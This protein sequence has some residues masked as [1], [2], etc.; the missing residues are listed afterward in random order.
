MSALRKRGKAIPVRRLAFLVNSSKAPRM[1]SLAKIKTMATSRPMAASLTGLLWTTAYPRPALAAS[2]WLI[3]GL[4]LIIARP[5]QPGPAFRLGMLAGLTH[6]LTSLYWLLY[7]PFPGGAITAWLALSLYL[8]LFPA[9][10]LWWVVQLHSRLRGDAE[11]GPVT[12]LG[13]QRRLLWAWLG[14]AAWVALEMLR[15]RLL[16]G[17]P[18]NFLGASQLSLPPLIQ[19][20]SVTG[21][22][23]IS[24]LIVWFSMSLANALWL[25]PGSPL[26]PWRWALEIA[27]PALAV[28]AAFTWGLQRMAH[29]PTATRSVKVALIQPSIPQTLIWDPQESTNRF[30]KLLDLSNLALAAKPELLIWPESAVPNMLRYD[31]ELTYPAVTNLVEKNNVWLILGA[32]DVDPASGDRFPKDRFYNSSFLVSPQGEFKATYRKL[33]LVIFGEYVPLVDWLPFLK[34]L[35]PIGDGFT[36]GAKTVPFAIPDLQIHTSVLICFEDTF[37][38]ATGEYVQNDTDFL[39]NITNDGWFGNSAAQWQHAFNAA[40][41]AVEYGL[42]L[43]RCANNGLTCW[44]DPLGR[45]HDVY[46]GDSSD[47]YGPGFKIVQIPLRPPRNE[48]FPTFYHRHGDWFGWSCVALVM[49]IIS[50]NKTS[51]FLHTPRFRMVENRDETICSAAVKKTL[52][53]DRL[54]PKI[55]SGNSRQGI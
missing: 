23:G 27:L 1:G 45:L 17:F 26:R 42:P 20:C 5:Q 9:V 40:F 24:F 3:P 29:W 7:M 18:W 41:R 22:Y 15:G 21:I 46:F 34:W 36:P 6:Y 8:S 12:V 10:W 52:D 44:V 39:V 30:L 31:P 53:H 11:F 50:V 54:K 19:L 13:W 4:L 51:S 47:V 14:A 38:H 49:I 43:V 37:P 32:D 16:T 28:V 2:A 25:L 33:R 48:L 55:S 35:T